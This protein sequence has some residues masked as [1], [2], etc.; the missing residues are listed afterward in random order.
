MY[1]TR[2]ATGERTKKYKIAE[3]ALQACVGCEFKCAG[4][5]EVLDKAL[6]N[7]FNPRGVV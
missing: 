3:D 2:F 4:I 1:A 6:P 7:E 5:V